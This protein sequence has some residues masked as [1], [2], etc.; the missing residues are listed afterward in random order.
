MHGETVKCTNTLFRKNADFFYVKI[1][2]KDNN[3]WDLWS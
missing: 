2:D 3:D 1:G